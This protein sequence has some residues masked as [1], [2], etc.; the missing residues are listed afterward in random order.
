M[1]TITIPKEEYDK[2]VRAAR[3]LQALETAGVDNWG[4]YEFAQEVF[5]E[6]EKEE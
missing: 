5:D 1:E 3:W 6:L 2:L 4:G